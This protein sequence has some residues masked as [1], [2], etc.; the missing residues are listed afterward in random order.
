[1]LQEVLGGARNESCATQP[2]ALDL[3]EDALLLI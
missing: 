2:V 3:S 1:M